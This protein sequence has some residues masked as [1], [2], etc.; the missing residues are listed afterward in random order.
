[1]GLNDK[2]TS[3]LIVEDQFLVSEMI[4]SILQDM[5]YQVVGRATN[6]MDAIDLTRE[7]NPDVVMMDIEMPKMDGIEACRQIQACCPRPVVIMTAYETSGLVSRASSA[8][9]GAYLVKPPN[10]REI[11][12]AIAIA[13]ARFNDMQELR[14]LNRE[15]VQ[16]NQVKE[17]LIKELQEALSNIQTLSGLLP[18]CSSCK[19]IRDDTGYWHQVE[20]YIR[21]HSDTEFSH[22]LCPDCLKKLYPEFADEVLEQD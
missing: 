13:T 1:M 3:V 17:S 14:R 21:S 19:K 15:L 10:G 12:R 9:A 22:G 11:D 7:L 8:G 18:I 4:T 5:G 6:G 16:I 2:Q 20:D